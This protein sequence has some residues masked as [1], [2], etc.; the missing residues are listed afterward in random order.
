MIAMAWK[1][2][3]VYIIADAHAPKYWPDSFV[4]YIDSYGRHK[5]MFGTDFPVLAFERYRREV[6]DLGLRAESYKAFVRGNAERV[7]KL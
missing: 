6:D 3:N 7:F 5:V 4:R 2:D 1:H